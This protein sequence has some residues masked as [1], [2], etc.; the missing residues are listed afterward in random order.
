MVINSVF[1]ACNLWPALSVNFLNLRIFVGIHNRSLWN[2]KPDVTRLC[3]CLCEAERERIAVYFCWQW[4]WLYVFLELTYLN[5]YNTKIV[6]LKIRPDSEGSAYV[7]LP[8]QPLYRHRFRYEGD[9][10]NKFTALN[11][12]FCRYSLFIQLQAHSA[13]ERHGRL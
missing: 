5:P 13:P 9:V 4:K 12:P 6:M 10:F 2:F 1:F 3:V 7:I 11:C 8:P